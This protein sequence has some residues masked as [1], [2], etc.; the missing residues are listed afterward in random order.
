[1]D[2][3]LRALIRADDDN[4]TKCRLAAAY[5]AGKHKGKVSA[6]LDLD[7]ERQAKNMEY[8]KLLAIVMGVIGQTDITL[9]EPDVHYV[10][11]MV[12]V[13]GPNPDDRS[14]RLR[15]LPAGAAERARAEHVEQGRKPR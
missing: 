5:A 4:E 11:G 2:A 7:P 13:L 8:M 10:D 12:I 9:R 1:M 14:I 3:K 6:L 15:L